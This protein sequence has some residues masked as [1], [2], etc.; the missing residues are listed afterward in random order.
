MTRYRHLLLIIV[1]LSLVILAESEI[2]SWYVNHQI[3][4]QKIFFRKQ[5]CGVILSIKFIKTHTAVVTKLI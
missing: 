5:R 4:L 3:A 2:I 1:S